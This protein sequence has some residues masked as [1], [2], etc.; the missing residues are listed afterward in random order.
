MNDQTMNDEGTA[1]HGNGLPEDTALLAVESVLADEGFTGQ[2]IA[3]PEA[4]VLCTNCRS[5]I[6]AAWLR[7]DEVTRLEGA[8]DP[9][10]MLV[11]I[12]L[13]CPVCAT[14]GTLIINFGPEMGPEHDMVFSAMRRK[15]S[16]GG[17]VHAA[18][19]VT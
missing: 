8:S 7:A 19:G 1:H 10:D 6:A 4:R 17:G 14:R 12:P 3:A 2:F 16:E 11:V 9:A 18:P 5:L 15:P 13:T